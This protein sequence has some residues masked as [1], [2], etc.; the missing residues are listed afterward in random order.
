M[1]L[2]LENDWGKKKKGERYQKTFLDNTFPEVLH[3]RLF[4][5]WP[6]ITMMDLVGENLRW[7][8]SLLGFFTAPTTSLVSHGTRDLESCEP[9]KLSLA[10]LSS[11]NTNL[12]D[13]LF[14]EYL[15]KVGVSEFSIQAIAELVCSRRTEILVWNSRFPNSPTSRELPVILFHDAH[16]FHLYG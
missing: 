10:R 2:F 12:W 16:T 1:Y 11:V 3:T 4:E 9:R 8:T 15:H 5:R 6:E 13:C 7:H 14:D